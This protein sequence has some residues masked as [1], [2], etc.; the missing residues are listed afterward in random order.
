MQTGGETEKPG[1]GGRAVDRRAVL[2]AVGAA[3]ALSVGFG[4][5]TAVFAADGPTAERT[6]A[7]LAR[8]SVRQVP[9]W[10]A[11]TD[12]TVR[13]YDDAGDIV[14][15]GQA[16]GYGS[17]LFEDVEP[18]GG[19]QV[20]ATVDGEESPASEPVEVF[21]LA[22]TP[23]QALY[24]DQTLAEGFGYIETRDGTTLAEQVLFPDSE[25]PPYPTVIIH[26]G[27]EPS[28]NF[29]GGSVI[30]DVIVEEYGYAVVGVNMRGSACSGGRF[31]L[32]E[33]LQ[34]RDGYDMV[35]T[36]AAQDW[37]DG[38]ALGGA[39][40]SGFTQL[41]VAATQ[42]PSL[43][44][45]VPGHP[46]GEFY[47]DTV[48]PGGM[49]NV[50]FAQFWASN[51]DSAFEPGG[52]E[53]NVDERIANGDET[54]EF[55]Q[56]LRLQNEAM[57]DQLVENDVYGE[58]YEQRGIFGRLDDIEVPTMLVVSWQDEQTGG[59]SA[60]LFEELPAETPAHLLGTNGDHFEY[61]SNGVLSR[62]DT[63]LTLYLKAEIP[64]GWP[65][66]SY[67]AA[68]AAYQS[69]PVTVTWERDQDSVPAAETSH[70]GWPA[71][72]VG[73]ME[74]FL[75]PDGTLAGSPPESGG[76]SATSYAFRSPTLTGQLIGRDG[77]GR[78]DW[79]PRDGGVDA[80]FVSSPL[81]VALPCLGSAVVELWLRSTASNTDLQVTLSEVRP[82]G[83]EQFV[84]NGWLRASHRAEAPDLSKPR[85][86]WHTHRE[87]DIE[88]LPDDG[89]TRVRVE[90]FP[91][92]HVFRA[93]SRVR[94]AIE[95]PGGNRDLWAFDVV[96]EPATNEIAHSVAHPSKL[97]LPVLG[98]TDPDVPGTAPPCDT[99]RH[100]PCRAGEPPDR[101][102]V[103]GVV[104]DGDTSL[105]GEQV[106]F[107][108]VD[109]TTTGRLTTT[110]GDGSYGVSLVPGSYEVAVEHP[111]YETAD[112][113]VT[114]DPGD[115]ATVDVEVTPAMGPVAGG[116]RPRD[117]DGDGLFEDID[118]NGEF[119]IFDVQTLFD[120]LDSNEVQ[121]YSAAFDFDGDGEVDIFDVQALFD[122][123]D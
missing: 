11:G 111:L 21:P 73:T 45:I 55:N 90:L 112:T 43:A 87:A 99:V 122:R 92:G 103:T 78:L 60:R 52:S 91:F 82:D 121:Q 75:Q 24:D 54:C 34:P 58:L 56:Q 18:G 41:Y 48:Y 47:R 65:H 39:S 101:A 115:T 89:F 53:G 74:L 59:R 114:I 28:V 8:G 96:D 51:R 102:T 5:G 12:A 7:P 86:P 20:T 42:P 93:D 84:Q 57:S 120:N 72:D 64:E 22:Y 117:L 97:A 38:V 119:D 6:D 69:E 33:P 40:F 29:P 76:L 35:E 106:L 123:L 30:E 79:Q 110:D 94:I 116:N 4:T 49:R 80:G 23:P 83:T 37:A 16:D 63:F 62:M 88:P 26:S 85:R 15:S 36:V 13:L 81:G 70:A 95:E 107:L 14:A 113:A 50:T 98:D 77:Q 44:A 46:I 105:G 17:H 27:Y 104:T 108:S 25:E 109:G 71:P 67:E 66:D 31:D 3:G 68:L 61:I 2:E 32:G 19:Y 10:Y 9:V 100:Q 1:R 118:G